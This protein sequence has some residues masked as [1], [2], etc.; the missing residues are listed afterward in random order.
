MFRVPV[1]AC[2]PEM[3]TLRKVAVLPLKTYKVRI[4]KSRSFIKDTRDLS[5]SGVLV[6]RTW[7][8]KGFVTNPPVTSRNL[9]TPHLRHVFFCLEW[10]PEALPS[11]CI[12]R[13]RETTGCEPME[14]HPPTPYRCR[15]GEGTTSMKLQASGEVPRGKK[16]SSLGPT[17]SRIFRSVLEYTKMKNFYPAQ[18]S[19]QG[20]NLALTIPCDGL[21]YPM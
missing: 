21:D 13:V 16:C 11:G 10:S 12:E 4:F 15:D 6:T 3:A 20:Q 5:L 19:S 2:P 9:T 8:A 18:G 7:N 14:T 17:Q 1:I